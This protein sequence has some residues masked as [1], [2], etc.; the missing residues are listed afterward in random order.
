[1]KNLT[2]LV[3]E[4][5][6]LPKEIEWFEFKENLN[7][8][9]DIGEYISAL[10]NAATLHDKNQAYLIWGVNDA[11]EIV[12][13]SFDF[14][15]DKIGGE[16]LEN[17]LRRLLSDNANFSFHKLE[18]DNK[19][20]NMLIIYSAIYQTVKFKNIDYIRVGS[21][22]KKL[23]DHPSIES[24]LWHKINMA[25]FERLL[26]KQDL[27]LLDALN[28]LDYSLYFDLTGI[29]MPGTPMKSCIIYWKN[30]S[31]Q[32]KIMACTR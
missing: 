4:L 12:G 16:E 8:S 13:T 1:M 3:R 31:F 7:N 19:P 22:K 32:S 17:W 11:H 15:A 24:Q 5:I 21:Y 2:A 26:A 27:Q 14:S 29:A 28:L 6:K 30:E 10:S 23:K 25:R 18:I 9:D 20:V